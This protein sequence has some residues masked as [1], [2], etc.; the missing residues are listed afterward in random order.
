MS[1]CYVDRAIVP[2]VLL[3]YNQAVKCSD[4]NLQELRIV[5]V[6]PMH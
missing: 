6:N 1:L 2:C 4:G 5:K 3:G